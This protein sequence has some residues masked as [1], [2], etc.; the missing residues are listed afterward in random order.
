M[1]LSPLKPSLSLSSSSAHMT[2]APAENTLTPQADHTTSVYDI[3][4]VLTM[5]IVLSAIQISLC[6]G[7]QWDKGFCWLYHILPLPTI[8]L[9]DCMGWINAPRDL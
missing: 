9:V 5:T 3:W 7:G 1:L 8:N 6:A 2:Y 4:S